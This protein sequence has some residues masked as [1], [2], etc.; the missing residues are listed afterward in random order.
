MAS[1]STAG[2]PL[3]PTF[4]GYIGTTMDAL[5]LFEAC[6]TGHLTHIPRRP[7]DRERHS[8]IRSGNIFIYEEHSSGIKRWTDGIPWSPSRILNNFLLYR[9]LEKPFQPGEKKR[10]MRR[11]ARTDG[12]T[13]PISRNR[14]DTPG[15][16]RPGLNSTGSLVPTGG[17]SSSMLSIPNGGDADRAYIGSLVDSYKFKENGLIKKTISVQHQGVTHHLVSYY[18]LDDIKSGALKRVKSSANMRNIIPRQSLVGSN[19]FRCPVDDDSEMDGLDTGTG[20]YLMS[21][22]YGTAQ[23]TD[24]DRTP[25][26]PQE[27]HY[28]PPNSYVTSSQFSHNPGYMTLPQTLP[29]STVQFNQPQDFYSV[30][31]GYGVSAPSGYHPAVPGTR[32]TSYIGNTNGT[33]PSMYAGSSTTLL[34][35]ATGLAGQFING[36]MFSPSVSDPAADGSAGGSAGSYGPGGTSHDNVTHQ[37]SNHAQGRFDEHLSNG[38]D[39]RMGRVNESGFEDTSYETAE[40]QYGST[41]TRATPPNFGMAMDQEEMQTEEGWEVLPHH[42]HK[43]EEPP[44]GY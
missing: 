12:V 34:P 19:T 3:A 4:H 13:K 32:T 31:P 44:N 26:M 20:F 11:P 9:E 5:I 25:L 10:A 16:Y 8:L 39:M 1:R 38:L 22:S 29:Q 7:Q 35:N 17:I 23:H 36:D 2:N 6:L 42:F 37:F 43:Q 40:H 14:A 33:S 21:H 24:M 18:N 30:D 41:N 15:Q 27:S 28:R